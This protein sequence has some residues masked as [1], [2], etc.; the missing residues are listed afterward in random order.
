[1]WRVSVMQQDHRLID[2]LVKHWRKRRGN[3]A[4]PVYE[5]FS[6][7]VLGDDVWQQ[8]CAF[9]VHEEHSKTI[10]MGDFAGVRARQA[11][12]RDITGEVLAVG[13]AQFEAARLLN[14]AEKALKER[15]VEL[16]EGHFVNA[17]SKIIKFR[18]CLLPFGRNSRVTHLLLGVSW[19]A[20]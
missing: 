3:L 6:P 16:D 2:N 18:S 19:R 13:A 8:C 5:A 7:E 20:F 17:D 15:D 1:M 11:L 12:G 4:L 10:L 14:N 9:T